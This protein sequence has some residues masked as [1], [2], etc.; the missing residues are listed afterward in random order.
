[1]STEIR[2]HGDRYSP[3]ASP[4]QVA[5]DISAAL[6]VMHS[7]S[8]MPVVSRTTST[9]WCIEIAI[10]NHDKDLADPIVRAELEK[11]ITQTAARFGFDASVP[12]IDHQERLFQVRVAVHEDYWSSRQAASLDSAYK[13]ISPAKLLAG[14]IPG[15]SIE[16]ITNQRSLRI[17]SVTK[18]AFVT[19]SG[20]DN[21]AKLLWHAP[22]AAALRVKG[23][24]IRIAT[25]STTTPDK[26]ILLKCRPA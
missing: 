21:Q 16:D 14:L 26:H 24:L 7:G 19:D 5:E 11:S 4:N 1:M 12:A 6:K 20:V 23:D 25:G 18:K 13:A 8:R 15:A 10:V 9:S 22:R 3:S 2:E 17:L